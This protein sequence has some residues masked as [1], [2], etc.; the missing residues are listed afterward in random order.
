MWRCAG[1]A[2][3]CQSPPGAHITRRQPTAARSQLIGLARSPAYYDLLQQPPRPPPRSATYPNCYQQRRRLVNLSAGAAIVSWWPG[4]IL[5]SIDRHNL[6]LGGRR[7]ARL[8]SGGLKKLEQR[9]PQPCEPNLWLFGAKMVT[10][11]G[12]FNIILCTSLV[13]PVSTCFDL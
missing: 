11:T 1:L 7:G 2:Y 9:R 12:F 13:T 5:W 4:I 10:T 8:Y 3:R 6:A